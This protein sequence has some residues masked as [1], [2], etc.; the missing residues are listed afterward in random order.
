[1]LK[2]NDSAAFY[3]VWGIWTATDTDTDGASQSICRGD[4]YWLYGSDYVASVMGLYVKILT[5]SEDPTVPGDTDTY[6]IVLDTPWGGR[7]DSGT[8]WLSGVTIKLEFDDLKL[9]GSCNELE[10]SFSELRYYVDGV[11]KKTIG[12][13]S[14]TISPW[15]YRRIVI[16]GGPSATLNPEPNYSAPGCDAHW[17]DVQPGYTHQSTGDLEFRI[18]RNSAYLDID[19]DNGMAP[20]SLS[21]G[22]CDEVTLPLLEWDSGTH[23]TR[24]IITHSKDYD[25]RL[26]TDDGVGDCDCVPGPTIVPAAGHLWHIFRKVVKNYSWVSI[27]RRD[28]PMRQ[29][30]RH[31]ETICFPVT[32]STDDT[33]TTETHCICQSVQHGEEA[34]GTTYCYEILTPGVCGGDGG[35]GGGS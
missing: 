35:D 1:M 19:I 34:R 7:T 5:K 14:Q 26:V 17:A 21:C 10:V 31:K 30:F 16:E 18:K 22:D 25:Y 29:H 33:T 9:T 11:L 8:T 13:S 3:E 28:A 27:A 20:P 23:D 4:I 6:S 15:S 12:A 24:S 2:V 32:S